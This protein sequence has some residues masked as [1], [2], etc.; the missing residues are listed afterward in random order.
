[1]TGTDGTSWEHFYKRFSGNGEYM[2]LEAVEDLI[3]IAMHPCRD[4]CAYDS[5]YDDVP[6]DAWHEPAAAA[7]HD[8]IPGPAVIR[9][10]SACLIDYAHG[11][12]EA[13]RR[14][15]GGVGTDMLVDLLALG[16]A[17]IRLGTVDEDDLLEVI[18]ASRNCFARLRGLPDIATNTD[19]ASLFR[20]LQSPAALHAVMLQSEHDE[21][22]RVLLG[23]VK[24][25][26]L[27]LTLP[28]RT[29]SPADHAAKAEVLMDSNLTLIGAVGST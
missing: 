21:I 29:P 26:L 23:C 4:Y 1:M 11:P 14:F 27:E 6:P 17:A 3:A 5:Y 7:A 8:P 2:N 18:C 24:C 25:L 16:N 13:T 10:A 22:L 19:I 9:R 12:G 15:L 28:Q 20:L